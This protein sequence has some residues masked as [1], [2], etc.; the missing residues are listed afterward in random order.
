MN[1]TAFGDHLQTGNFLAQ[2]I[3]DLD[4]I[5]RVGFRKQGRKLFASC[6]A[7]QIRFA[8]DNPGRIHEGLQ[9]RI[10]SRMTVTIVDSLEVIQIHQKQNKGMAV[11]PMTLEFT[12]G[13]IEKLSSIK[14]AGQWIGGR[15][16]S[17]FSFHFAPVGDVGTDA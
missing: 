17:Q 14:C 2:A 10:A 11:A 8:K 4:G 1:A 6:A 9:G 3:G 12:L 5:L 7:E 15:Q 13:F 16:A